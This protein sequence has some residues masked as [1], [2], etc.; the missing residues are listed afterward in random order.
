MEN[1]IQKDIEAIKERNRKVEI[2]KDWETSL[3]RKIL[4]AILTYIV[5]VLFFY[6]ADFPKPFINAVV[7]TIGF[8]LSTLSI[9]VAKRIWIKHFYRK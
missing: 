1:D 8:L 7:P 9:S 5:I 6:F 4:I 2:D 3:T